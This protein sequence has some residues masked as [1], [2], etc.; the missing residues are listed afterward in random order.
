MWQEA[1]VG[2]ELLLLHATPVYYGIG[3]PH[4]DGSGVILIPGFL[5]SVGP[6]RWDKTRKEPGATMER[7]DRR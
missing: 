1:L 6:M 5:A 3:V 4:G 2:V 7:R